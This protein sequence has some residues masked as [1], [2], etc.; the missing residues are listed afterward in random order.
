MNKP[1]KKHV[2]FTR[3]EGK[4]NLF[5]PS[6]VSAQYIFHNIS[7]ET[8]L[9]VSYLIDLE[10]DYTWDNESYTA[11]EVAREIQDVLDSYR[12]HSDQKKIK[13]LIEYLESIEEEQEQ[14]QR[15]Y[16]LDYAKYQVDYWTNRVNELTA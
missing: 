3:H 13:A 8:G 4:Y 6:E 16:D 15:E 2:Y 10:K 9:Q 1:D 5:N 7:T 14:I 11:L 12:F